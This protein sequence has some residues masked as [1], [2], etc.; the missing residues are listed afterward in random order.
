MKFRFE[1]TLHFA[2]A[3][4]L[5]AV[6]GPL[7]S[8]QERNTGPVRPRPDMTTREMQ[9]TMERDLLF[10]ELQKMAEHGG[11]PVARLPARQLALAQIHEDFTRIQVV[12]NK[13]AQSLGGGGGL[14]LK[15]VAQAASEIKKCAGRLK[16]NLALPERAA[17]EPRR[18]APP[19][20]GPEQLRDSVTA[21]DRLVLS[22]INNPGF[23]SVDVIDAEW[24]FKARR[25][26]EEIIELSGRLRKS[27]EQL[28]K[29][30]QHSH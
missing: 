29:A 22:F 23:Q 30:A 24:S 20:I 21:L 12:N 13:L 2:T 1:P 28:H 3:L 26:L 10:K 11:D 7:C 16:D 15:L 19:E 18:L 14:D 25:D 6:A 17:N 27:S 5:T 9:R 8:G 4:V